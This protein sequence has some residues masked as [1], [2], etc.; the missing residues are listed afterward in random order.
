MVL[1]L[2]ELSRQ[3]RRWPDRPAAVGGMIYTVGDIVS[4]PTGRTPTGWFGYTRS[5]TPWWPSP[6]R[7]TTS[8][9]SSV[10]PRRAISPGPDRPLRGLG[11][12][13]PATTR[14][15]GRPSRAFPGPSP[16]TGGQT[17]GRERSRKGCRT[18]RRP[19]SPRRGPDDKGVR[20]SPSPVGTA[21]ST[22]GW[23]RTGRRSE[24]AER[25][26]APCL[27]PRRR[28]LHG[29]PRPPVTTTA[30]SR[31]SSRP[32]CRPNGTLPRRH[33]PHPRRRRALDRGQAMHAIRPLWVRSPYMCGPTKIDPL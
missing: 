33:L 11:R 27:A 3:A 18:R 13:A 28:R 17:G 5:G 12:R 31:A 8:T 6:A 23:L 32:T 2:P 29:P 16:T 24:D 15:T 7:A 22:H 21:T 14:S 30:P 25:R 4:A 1:A 20:P 19:R 26:A 9:I 10:V